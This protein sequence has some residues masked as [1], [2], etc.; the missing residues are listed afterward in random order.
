V[1][2]GEDDIKSGVSAARW[3]ERDAVVGEHAK[4]RGAVDAGHI[5]L[6]AQVLL[7]GERWALAAV[8]SKAK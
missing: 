5:K 3:R 2:R 1:S 7:H 6:V 4:G 8:H